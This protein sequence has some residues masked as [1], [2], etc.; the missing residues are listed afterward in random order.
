[1]F[2]S[3]PTIQTI[4]QLEKKNK[5]LYDRLINKARETRQTQ[6]E[7]IYKIREY[8][9]QDENNEIT[10]DITGVSQ[11]VLDIRLG[12][13]TPS[14][15]IDWH[16][17]DVEFTPRIASLSDAQSGKVKSG[18]FINVPGH[19]AIP[20]QENNF[21]PEIANQITQ[22]L[23]DNITYEYLKKQ[24]PVPGAV[25][26]RL[27]KSF[28][29]DHKGSIQVMN[30]D[31]EYM[32]FFQ[33]KKI[34]LEDPEEVEQA[35]KD[36]QAHLTAKAI[37]KKTGKAGYKY[38]TNDGRFKFDNSFIGKP[39]DTFNIEDGVLTITKVPDYYEFVK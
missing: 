37:N 30:K 8:L 35:K 31:G 27:V 33:G 17:S 26:E 34:N 29:Y 22:L 7:T 28:V 21:T 4:E 32:V 25:R 11:G 10:V 39:F 2:T 13:D 36:I 18:M 6:L 24:V 38:N 19:R 15:S 3:T 20:L 9:S 5:A 12:E 1:M 23:F 14:N 16:G